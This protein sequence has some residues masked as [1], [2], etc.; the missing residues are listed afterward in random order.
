M[1]CL[2]HLGF[3]DLGMLCLQQLGFGIW[4]A[5]SAAGGI[6]GCKDFGMTG[7]WDAGIWGCLQQLGFEDAGVWGCKDFWK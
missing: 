4:D 6:F 7:F 2:Q 5:V 1:L 3:R